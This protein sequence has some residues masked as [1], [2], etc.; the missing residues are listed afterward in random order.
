MVNNQAENPLLMESK[1]TPICP[2][3]VQQLQGF[4][5]CGRDAGLSGK[6]LVAKALSS[7][8]Q[9]A[10]IDA[11]SLMFQGSYQ[12]AF[13]QKQWFPR[14]FSRII[15]NS[16]WVTLDILQTVWEMD[17][18]KIVNECKESMEGLSRVKRG[19]RENKGK[20]RGTEPWK[21]GKNERGTEEREMEPLWPL[22]TQVCW[23][24]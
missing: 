1:Y 14:K 7:Y 20:R 21:D 3:T 19:N 16:F 9:C 2:N 11:T 22:W 24:L 17:N 18:V 5:L 10:K 4:I 13:T 8:I 6:K 12:K 23:Q 15:I